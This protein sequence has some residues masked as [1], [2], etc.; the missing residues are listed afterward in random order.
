LKKTVSGIMLT[1]LLMGMLTLAFNI[2]P[3]TASGTIYIRANGSVEP[4]TAPIQRDGNVYTFTSNIYDNSIVIERDSIILDGNG[5]TLEGTETGF[6]IE[7]FSRSDVTIKNIRIKAF[8]HGI[9]LYESS[10]NTISG[11]SIT[12]N[13]NDGI[14]LIASPNNIVLKNKITSNKNGID[15]YASSYN[16]ISQ[17]L[18][19]ENGYYGIILYNYSSTHNTIN[20]NSIAYN[21]VGV[22]L[23]GDH[24]IVYHNNFIDNTD[25]CLDSGVSNTWDNGYPS[26][27][28]YWSDY[29]GV[30]EFS[31]PNQDLLGSD[32]IGDTPYV[33]DAH[34]Q[35]NYPLMNPWVWT[36]DFA[37][38][39]SPTSQT[40]TPRKST[41]YTVTIT[42]IAGFSS[43]VA[44]SSSINPSSKRISLTFDSASV[45][46]PPDSSTELTLTVSTTGNVKTNFYT[47]TITGSSEDKTH[48]ATV[49]LTIAWYELF[50]EI[51]YMEGHRPTDTVLTYIQNYYIERGISVTFHV[52]DT[53]PYDSVVTKTE[54]WAIE[55]EY[56]NKGDDWAGGDHR[57]G[58][59]FSKWKWVLFG[60]EYEKPWN[61]F[62]NVPLTDEEELAWILSTNGGNYIFI[63][64]KLNDDAASGWSSEG[65]TPEEVEAVVLMHEMGHSI[66]ILNLR[67]DL[68]DDDGDGDRLEWV[69]F[70]DLNSKSVM[71]RLTTKNCNADPI[72]YSIYYWMMKNLQYYKV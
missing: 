65:V 5:F 30:D 50:F 1:L 24:N 53:V 66:G 44:L 12:K 67:L 23:I 34:N 22:W 68:F 52:N 70:Y 48:S 16:R 33:I 6:G 7:L 31:G 18:I 71:A 20:A 42:S 3:V 58:V 69:E 57:T 11:N 59:Y 26:G 38:S 21:D 9:Y 54:F 25:Q 40:I 63:A 35:D 39:V 36:P 47:I 14:V 64:D 13:T 72:G 8:V 37:I 49:T 56:N 17:N 19:A 43:A 62:C 41:R 60:A 27:G 15:G 55:N 29:S 51:D 4:S 46:P 45:T 10:N 2:Q 28:N 32:E 61:G